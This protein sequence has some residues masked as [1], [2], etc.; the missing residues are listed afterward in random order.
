MTDT[1]EYMWQSAASPSHMPLIIASRT[2]ELAKIF[3]D[4]PDVL[5]SSIPEA[6]HH[7]SPRGEEFAFE[8]LVF[9]AGHTTETT[10][11]GADDGGLEVAVRHRRKTSSIAVE[12]FFAGPMAL[13]YVEFAEKSAGKRGTVLPL[14]TD[15]A[16]KPAHI[17]RCWR[18]AATVAAA[19]ADIRFRLTS[20]RWPVVR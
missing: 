14:D 1:S 17:E 6:E 9:G 12:A 19:M 3:L 7:R 8:S 4:N 10:I 20:G 2:L 13:P 15:N 18:V 11:T 5:T 16:Y